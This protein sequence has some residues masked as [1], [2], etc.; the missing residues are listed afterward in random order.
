MSKGSNQLSPVG[1]LTGQKEAPQS[2]H[3][4]GGSVEKRSS[5]RKL[6]YRA[7]RYVTTHRSKA[8]CAEIRRNSK[9]E[10]RNTIDESEMSFDLGRS[11]FGQ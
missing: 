10:T 7:L 1:D 5:Y 11:K 4:T 8:L 6:G 9:L 2:Q 3:F